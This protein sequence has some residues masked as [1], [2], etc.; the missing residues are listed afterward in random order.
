M[1]DVEVLVCADDPPVAARVIDLSRAAGMPAYYAGRLENAV[2]VEGLTAIL[3]SLNKHYGGHASIRVTGIG[4]GSP[5][6]G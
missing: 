2:V 6:G 4:S 3:I 1:I 5:A